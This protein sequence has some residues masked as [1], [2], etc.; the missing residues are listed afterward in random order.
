MDSITLKNFRSLFGSLFIIII[1]QVTKFIVKKFV[2]PDEP[3]QIIDRYVQLNHITNPGLAFGIKIGERP[4]LIFFALIATIVV[5][6]LIFRLKED[7]LWTRIAL[8]S[9]LGG[10]I[11]NLID[12]IIFGEVVD[13]IEIGPWPIFNIADVAVTF[14]MIILIIHLLFDKKKG[15]DWQEEK[16]SIHG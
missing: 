2:H 4:F 3:I 6:I 11:G 13:F 9:I 1:D 14:G 5:L 10:A 7:H 12:R 8:A 16:F 15:E